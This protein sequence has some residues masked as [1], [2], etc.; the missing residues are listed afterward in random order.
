MQFRD[1]I[2]LNVVR[3]KGETMAEARRRDRGIDKI[4]GNPFAPA[5][6]DEFARMPRNTTVNVDHP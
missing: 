3:G 2:V 5:P 1:R 4:Q 6:P